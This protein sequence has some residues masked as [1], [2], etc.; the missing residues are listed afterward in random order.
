MVQKQEID[1]TIIAAH[2]MKMGNICHANAHRRGDRD[3]AVYISML[4]YACL[5]GVT[6]NRRCSNVGDRIIL[7]IAII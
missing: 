6:W 7:A 3:Q 1:Q 2:N 4:F 5:A